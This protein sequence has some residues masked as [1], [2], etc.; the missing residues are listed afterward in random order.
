MVVRMKRRSYWLGPVLGAL[1]ACGPSVQT[2]GEEGSATSGETEAGGSSSGDPATSSTETAGE[3]GEGSTGSSGGAAA[4]CGDG[5]VDADEGCDDGNLDNADGCSATCE[6][7]GSFRWTQALAAGFGT[8]LTSRD[9]R[10]VSAVQQFDA[11]FSPVIVVEGFDDVGTR[12]GEFVDNGGLSD[13]SVARNPVELLPDGTVALAYPVRSADDARDFAVLDLGS[14]L[15]ATFS[16]GGDGWVPGYGVATSAAAITV[17]HGTGIEDEPGLVLERFDAEANLLESVP[18][19]LGPGNHRP[20]FR[21]GVLRRDFPI[22]AFLTSRDDGAL[23]LW[24]FLPGIEQVYA[25]PIGDA[26]EDARPSAF[27]SGGVMWIWNGAELLQTDSQDHIVASEPRAFEG[28][29]V[30]ADEFGLVTDADGELILYDATGAEQLRVTLPGGEE[31]P[32]QASFVRP[33]RRCWAVRARR[34][35]RSGRRR[36]GWSRAARHAALRRSVVHRSRIFIVDVQKT[37][38]V[39]PAWRT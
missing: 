37:S 31:R 22:S 29:L 30:W 2:P 38:M 32:V 20:F 36:S 28:D 21:G 13:I 8:G 9:G 23:E 6:V 4:V 26:A 1:L 35:R 19:D 17:V 33:D 12:L 34:P 16:D 14:G 39:W 15:V 7:S 3:S 10:V 25:G 27:S 5:I 11:S 18:L 24:S